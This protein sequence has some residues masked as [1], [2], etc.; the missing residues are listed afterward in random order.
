MRCNS[1]VFI[2]DGLIVVYSKNSIFGHLR[3]DVQWCLSDFCQVLSCLLALYSFLR[4]DFPH[5]ATKWGRCEVYINL[6]NIHTV[7]FA[8]LR[9]SNGSWT[10]TGN[11]NYAAFNILSLCH[12]IN[13]EKEC[14]YSM[15]W[16]SNWGQEIY[17]SLQHSLTKDLQT[18][19]E[20]RSVTGS[21]A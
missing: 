18:R 12:S 19:L 1:F 7:A 6:C 15:S 9:L 5:V 16:I 8:L 4:F 21:Q 10:G 2:L 13:I 14:D 11:C 3:G 20:K 17:P